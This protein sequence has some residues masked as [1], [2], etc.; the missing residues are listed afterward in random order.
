[1]PVKQ[2]FHSNFTQTPVQMRPDVGEI[3]IQLHSI[4]Y[5][6]NQFHRSPHEADET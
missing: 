2:Q 6:E 1:M 5:L 3:K 4:R